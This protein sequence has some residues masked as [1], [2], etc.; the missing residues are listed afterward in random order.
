MSRVLALA[1]LLLLACSG[2]EDTDED[3][4]PEL[5]IVRPADNSP[6]TP[7]RTTELCLAV[8]DEDPVG[9]LLVTVESDQDGSLATEADGTSCSGGDLG[10]ALV[11]SDTTHEV[12]VSVEDTAGNTTQDAITLFPTP[13]LPPNCTISA[14]GDDT[15]WL[16]GTSISF[17]AT[18]GDDLTAPEDLSASLV[19]NGVTSLW[20]GS[21][22]AA[23]AVDLTL[24]ELEVGAHALVL[25]LVD[26][27]DAEGNCRID[28]VVYVCE[29]SDE[30]G[31]TNC[32]GDCNDGEATVYPGADEITDDGI[33]QDC[34]GTDTVQCATDNDQDGYGTLVP[35][36]A[37]D[38]SCDTSQH[39]AEDAGDCDDGDNSIHPGATEIPDDH[40]DQDCN[41]FDTISCFLDDDQ[42]GYG[43]EVPTTVFADDGVCNK[44]QK[45]SANTEDC[46]DTDA[47]VYPGAP[48]IPGNGTDENC[49]GED[50]SVCYADLDGDGIGDTDN[51]V[52]DSV[53]TGAGVSR[54]GGDCDDD[55][56]TVYPDAPS[57]CDGLNNDCTGGSWPT[58]DATEVDGD[59]DFYVECTDWVGADTSIDSGDCDPADG[60]VYPGAPKLCDGV[61][62]SCTHSDWP[63]VELDEVDNDGDDFVEC[64]TWVGAD[65]SLDGDDCD[66]TLSSVYPGAAELC[67]GLHNDC[68]DWVS[69]NP[70]V[71]S[72]ETDDDGDDHVECS[73]WVGTDASID[74]DDCHDGAPTVYPDAA[75]LCDGLNN[76]C[77]DTSYPIVPDDETNLDGDDFV[78][79]K[80]YVGP[81]SSLAGGDCDPTD[82][83]VYP[84]AEELCDGLH[85]DCNDWV[86]EA[87][88][89]PVDE[90]DNDSDTFVEC[91]GWVGA[92]TTISSGDCDDT[93]AQTFPNA[94]PNEVLKAGEPCMRDEDEDD[95]GDESPPAGVDVGT[96]CVDDP[97]G[98]TGPGGTT[99]LG[100]AIYPGAGDTWYDGI[101][102][103]CGK[104]NDYD[105]DGDGYLCDGAYD[106]NCAG[107]STGSDCVDDPAGQVTTGGDTILGIFINPSSGDTWYDGVDQN[108]DH[109]SDYDQDG[110]GYDC[111]NYPWVN[112][113]PGSTGDDCD[114]L[115]FDVN[116]GV[117]EIWYD[118]FDQDCDDA[119][120]FDQDGDSFECNPD[121]DPACPEYYG[122][123]CAD[124][125]P[126]VF[127]E[128]DELLNGQDDDCDAYCD[129]GLIGYGDLVVNEIMDN[130]H[131]QARRDKQ[132]FEIRNTTASDI[133][134]CEGWFLQS[135][136]DE[137]WIDWYTY[138]APL[139]Q[140]DG[141]YLFLARSEFSRNGGITF[142]PESMY[143]WGND[144][145]LDTGDME[146]IALVFDDPDAGAA[147]IIDEVWWDQSWPSTEGTAM[148]LN[149]NLPDPADLNDFA[150]SWC[151]SVATYT[152]GEQTHSGTPLQAN[153]DIDPTECTGP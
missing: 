120:D 57:L 110:D 1:A 128:A 105:R 113:C 19:S 66:D 31:V 119:S 34:N 62:N 13:N 46:D 102:Q 32:D 5:T 6:F 117:D 35:V 26:E 60:T 112:N 2:E 70:V 123:D 37:D 139:I 56:I 65:T 27:R 68:D 14:P 50:T 63:D 94:A 18:V 78:Q 118:G 114:D 147:L 129:E 24:S 3:Q 140:A 8:S 125:D 134:L 136:R 100:N 45:E 97:A 64:E 67:D 52:D 9:S 81:N 133:A 10:F 141:L 109:N 130:P 152:D 23:G 90:I 85:N 82:G 7:G 33:D 149:P 42:D 107:L 108:C 138:G 111:E 99:I 15:Q 91:P 40:I 95:W 104:D 59:S 137:L 132:W 76:D 38:G 71:P 88:V 124:T 103:D 61:N 55:E 101:D 145:D 79:C 153:N 22:T 43:D 12:T 36:L 135:A 116:P 87:P 98:A 74:G 44:E 122:E 148:A 144:F 48:E 28:I 72:D 150:P 30:D 11:L 29:D 142:V 53:C 49:D 84:A 16:S 39:E 25:T 89:V 41:V 54:E 83:T 47:T 86:S 4:S 115:V 20:S 146:R 51:T 80:P 73:P 121:Y 77:N 151:L 17:A 75:Q 126:L 69:G 96:D 131:G 106:S 93:S 92:D 21:P 58:P 143:A 127:P